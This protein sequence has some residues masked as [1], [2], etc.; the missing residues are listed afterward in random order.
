[1]NSSGKQDFV[2]EVSSKFVFPDWPGFDAAIAESVQQALTDGS[3]GRYHAAW[4]EKLAAMLAERFGQTYVGLCSSGTIAVELALRGAGVGPD[5]E[6]LL[7]AYDFP[8]NFRAIEAIGAR[9]V[10]VDVRPGGWC[11]DASQLDSIQGDRIKAVVVSH[12]HGEWADV[13]SVRD[14]ADRKGVQMVEDACQVPGASRAGRPAGSFGHCAA[15]SFGGS[16]LLTAGRGGA[17]LTS[18]R[19][20]LQR[21]KIYAE[22]GN[23]AFPL[24]QLQAAA[25][26]PQVARLAAFTAARDRAARDW[27]RLLDLREEFA[28]SP[29]PGSDLSAWYKLPIWLETGRKDDRAALLR[30]LQFEGVPID[31]GFRGFALR[32]SR[33]CRAIGL[34]PEARRAAEATLLLHHTALLLHP[35]EQMGLAGRIR[36]VLESLSPLN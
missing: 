6:V 19:Q 25:L 5:D 1:M 29:I 24:S 31:S 3:W 22:R 32:S 18:D 30:E 35:A 2:P 20:A 16:K 15:L 11:L 17:V 36:S 26:I 14:W 23:E 12:L 8:G 27:F 4:T 10:L 21:I 33:R 28:R 7:A 13:E 9:P 34:L